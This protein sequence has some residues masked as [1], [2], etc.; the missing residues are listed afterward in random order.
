MYVKDRGEQSFKHHYVTFL[1]PMVDFC[2]PPWLLAKLRLWFH[3]LLT[4]VVEL[5]APVDLL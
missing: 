3:G 4:S 5:H 1:I 2:P